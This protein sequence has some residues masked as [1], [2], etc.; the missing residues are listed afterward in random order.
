[1]AL[2]QRIMEDLKSAM[3][4][5]NAELLGVLRMLHASLKNKSIDKK[6]KGQSEELTDE[7]VIEVLGKEAKKRKESAEAFINGGRTDLAE[8]EK[9]ELAIVEAYLPKQMNAEE[10]RAAVEKI[11]SGLS[12]TSNFG[13]VMKT[14]MAE[15]KGKADAK[16][17]SEIIKEKVS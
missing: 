11:I 13:L 4:A 10:V 5:G 17:V 1:M 15:L 12:D 6:G 16:M 9:K 8:K 7:D 14:V 3:K 2:S